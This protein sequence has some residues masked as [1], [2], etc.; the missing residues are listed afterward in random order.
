MELTEQKLEVRKVRYIYVP[1][2]SVSSPSLS[3]LNSTLSADE[4]LKRFLVTFLFFLFRLFFVTGTGNV[5]LPD[6]AET[7]ELQIFLRGDSS[8]QT[9]AIMCH[10]SSFCHRNWFD[11]VRSSLSAYRGP[12][13]DLKR[14]PT[15][16]KAEDTW[17]LKEERWG[18]FEGGG[19]IGKSTGMS[20]GLTGESLKN[21]GTGL[22]GRVAGSLERQDWKDGITREIRSLNFAILGGSRLV[23][24]WGRE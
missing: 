6:P 23:S 2:V 14:Q 18:C 5:S 8:S 12:D 15:D 3:S 7:E 16:M 19:V 10:S 4:V 21:E 20:L 22:F 17:C 13:L 24:V 1:R 9:L 11:S